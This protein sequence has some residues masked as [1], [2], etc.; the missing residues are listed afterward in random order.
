MRAQD[1][2]GI[3]MSKPLT[4]CVHGYICANYQRLVECSLGTN[5]CQ[6]A[7]VLRNAGVLTSLQVC[8]DGDFEGELVAY[9]GDEDPDKAPISW[10]FRAAMNHLLERNR[11]T[12][13]DRLHVTL[14]SHI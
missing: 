9:N 1:M 10:A 14:G 5:L 6:V 7:P 13:K 12:S 3:D 8:L 4:P 2:S 11:V